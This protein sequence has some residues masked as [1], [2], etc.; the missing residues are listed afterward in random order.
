MKD[1]RVGMEAGWH[2]TWALPMPKCRA[3]AAV[4]RSDMNTD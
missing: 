1:Q 4:I 2:K 3:L